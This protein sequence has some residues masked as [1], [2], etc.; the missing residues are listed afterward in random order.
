MPTFSEIQKKMADYCAY[1]DR[2]HCEIEQKL[3][4]YRLDEDEKAEIWSYLINHDF[5]SEERF[6]KSFVRGKFYQKK[7]GK[8]KIISQLRL[9]QIPEKLIYNGLQEI[10]GQDYEKTLNELAGKKWI[11]LVEKNI[12]IQRKKLFSY[13]SQKGYENELIFKWLEGNS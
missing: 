5:L 6:A 3:Q 10:D 4:E 2:C 7:W 13:L 8:M 11:L 12:F 9:K 1:Q